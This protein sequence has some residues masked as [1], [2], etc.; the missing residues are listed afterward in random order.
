MLESQ[1]RKVLLGVGDQ[2][3]RGAAAFAVVE[4]RRRGVGVHIVHAV[5]LT[6]A[7]G[8]PL[9]VG[10][11]GATLSSVGGQ[12]LNAVARRVEHALGELPVSTELFHGSAVT[13]LVG[14]SRHA[15][16]VVLQH[17]TGGVR[18]RIPTLSV[19]NAVAAHAHA[20]VVVVPSDWK[21][22]DAAAG[23]VVAGI[24]DA[25]TARLIACGALAEARARG[26]RVRLV[27]AWRFDD[28]YD[29]VVFQGAAGPEHE[30]HLRHELA[31]A[32]APALA[33]YPDVTVEQVV[34]HTRAADLLVAESESADLVVVARHLARTPWSPHL[35]STVR[36]VLRESASPVLVLDPETRPEV[37]NDPPPAGDRP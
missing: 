12:I 9:V 2:D 26:A 17:R 14:A 5:P 20:P 32:V 3:V 35:G 25:A 16:V 21:A 34:V 4:A 28:Y 27:H 30:Q 33:D 19:A 8:E 7:G 22:E 6:T 37:T 11:D 10:A 13:A 31:A 15:G 1:P 36:A 23:V 24:G 18:P 29:D